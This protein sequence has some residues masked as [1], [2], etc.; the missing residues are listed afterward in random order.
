MDQI[1]NEMN[2]LTK[3]V[4]NS[5]EEWKNYQ[6]KYSSLIKYYQ[7]QQWFTDYTSYEHGEFDFKSEVLTDNGVY[8]LLTAQHNLAL[9]A[10]KT[11][12]STLEN[13]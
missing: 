6:K 7:S 13:D 10:I 8:N 12:T 4:H 9:N 5:I 11:A 1:L 2:D 3:K